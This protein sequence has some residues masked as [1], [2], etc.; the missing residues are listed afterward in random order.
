[1]LNMTTTYA[2]RGDTNENVYE[3]MERHVGAGK[4]RKLSVFHGERRRNMMATL[5]VNRD[6]EAAASATFDPDTLKP[7]W[8][9]KTRVGHPRTCWYNVTM[10]EIWKQAKEQAL[11]RSPE[12]F[13]DLGGDSHREAVIE[14][15]NRLLHA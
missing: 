3:R 2:N 5:I 6:T 9:G 4:I 11:I 13:P 14:A 8:R 12:D 10:E 7:H 1:M 15:A